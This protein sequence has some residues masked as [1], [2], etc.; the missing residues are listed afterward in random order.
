MRGVVRHA[1]TCG[2]LSARFSR[3]SGNKQRKPAFFF[4]GRKINSDL[5]RLFAID[6]A[7]DDGGRRTIQP[8]TLE[9]LDEVI[10]VLLPS[11]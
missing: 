2:P 7:K 5:Q 4:E 3:I 9:F 11:C 1:A 6:F 8:V 10:D